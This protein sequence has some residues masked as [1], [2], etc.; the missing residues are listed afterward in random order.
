MYLFQPNEHHH[1]VSYDKVFFLLHNFHFF[2]HVQCWLQI[3]MK[4]KSI[5]ANWTCWNFIST[6]TL[7]LN[8]K[9]LFHEI[10]RGYLSCDMKPRLNSTS[11]ISAL[12]ECLLLISQQQRVDD[13]ALQTFF[14]D[15]KIMFAQYNNFVVLLFLILFTRLFLCLFKNVF[16]VR[17]RNNYFR[18]FCFHLCIFPYIFFINSIFW[19]KSFKSFE[20]YLTF[21]F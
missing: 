5:S 21:L 17:L 12:G 4:P 18:V 2:S 14:H 6:K 16:H 13:A 8:I 19:S 7:K 20:I 9:N 11:I 15:V 1:R 3:I 10:S